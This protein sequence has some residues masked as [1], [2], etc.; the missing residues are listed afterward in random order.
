MESNALLYLLSKYLYLN[1]L[2][3]LNISNNS[4][5]SCYHCLVLIVISHPLFVDP[6]NA[7]IRA[8]NQSLPISILVVILVMILVSNM[9]H[10]N[11]TN[12]IYPIKTIS[13]RIKKGYISLKIISLTYTLKAFIQPCIRMPNKFNTQIKT[14]MRWMQILL[15]LRSY[16]KNIKTTFFKIL[17]L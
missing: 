17:A 9:Y 3:I 11:L 4:N 6:Y 2:N 1:I 5:T 14:S 15:A 8:S 7:I 10:V 12:Q 13:N 16:A